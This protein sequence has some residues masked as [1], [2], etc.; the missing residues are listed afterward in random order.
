MDCDEWCLSL[1]MGVVYD[2]WILLKIRFFFVDDW[3]EKVRENIKI[4]G[5]IEFVRVIL[6]I[7]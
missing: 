2:F 3:C 7:S 1:V 4:F 5:Y 6:W